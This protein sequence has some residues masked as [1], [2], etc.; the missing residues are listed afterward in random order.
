MEYIFTKNAPAP[1][2]TYSQAVKAKNM[3]FISGQIPIDIKTGEIVYNNIELETKIVLENLLNI[4][5]AADFKKEDIVKI[6]IFLKNINE[7]NVVNK[8]YAEIFS[9]H[10]P[11][12]AVVEVSNLPKNVDIEIEGICVKE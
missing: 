8:V 6:T 11:A 10:K 5:Y 1:I 9:H 4:V 12:R 3:L 7:F 2:G